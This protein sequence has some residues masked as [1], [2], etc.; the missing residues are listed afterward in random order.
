FPT[1]V[2][3]NAAAVLANQLYHT[4]MLLLLQRKPRFVT[5]VQPNSPDFSLLWQSHRICGIAVN[6]DRWDCW[7]P[8]LVASFLVAAKT[9]THQSQ[10][11]IILSTL[12]NIQEF[13]GWNV[14]HHVES[15][16]HEW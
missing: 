15:L 14:A 4:S 3:S 16:K 2:F 13:T 9:A 10:H 11:N 12:A 8:C 6:N 5:Q 1:L 7:D